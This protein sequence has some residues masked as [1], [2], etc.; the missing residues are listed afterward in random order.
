MKISFKSSSGGSGLRKAY[1]HDAGYDL[2][3][4]REE[5]PVTL[6]PMGGFDVNTRLRVDIP[7]GHCGL[8]LPR[9][10]S[11]RRALFAYPSVI[12]AG[13]T[14]EVHVILQNLSG[15]ETE[16][17]PGDAIAQMLFIP[18]SALPVCPEGSDVPVTAEHEK[19][20]ACGFGSSDM[21]E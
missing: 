6:P 5:I 7:P 15:T 16:I 21:E 11:S 2:F 19:R 13:Y 12:D 9:S 8:V 18:L 3:V 14:G 1:T 20:G 4:P 17:S 10:S